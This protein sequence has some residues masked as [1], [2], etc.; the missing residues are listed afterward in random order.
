MQFNGR[1][2]KEYCSVYMI[3]THNVLLNLCSWTN[4]VLPQMIIAYSYVV[5]IVCTPTRIHQWCDQGSDLHKLKINVELNI[6]RRIFVKVFFPCVVTMFEHWVIIKRVRFK[7]S[8]KV[9]LRKDI[10]HLD[11]SKTNFGH[12]TNTHWLIHAREYYILHGKLLYTPEV[13]TDRSEDPDSR[14]VGKE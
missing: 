14:R 3:N 6:N 5:D 7:I 4:F 13:I 11:P 2:F 1:T 8:H 12:V 9:Q 10:S